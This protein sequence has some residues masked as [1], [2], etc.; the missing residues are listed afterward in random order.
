MLCEEARVLL[1]LAPRGGQRPIE[2]AMRE[3]LEEHLEACANCQQYEAWLAETDAAIRR[4][5]TDTPVPGDLKERILDRLQRDFTGHA[6]A[7]PRA[8]RLTLRMGRRWA[9]GV[10][11]TAAGLIL[12]LLGLWAWLRN[13]RPLR[14]E[15]H[16]IAQSV[17]D[18]PVTDWRL[19]P[20]EFSKSGPDALQRWLDQQVGGDFVVPREVVQLVVKRFAVVTLEAIEALVLEYR[21]ILGDSQRSAEVFVFPKQRLWIP[22]LR[23]PWRQDSTS[24]SILIWESANHYCALR[25]RGP[26]KELQPHLRL[27]ARRLPMARVQPKEPISL[28]ADDSDGCRPVTSENTSERVSM[29]ALSVVS[30]TRGSPRVLK[31]A[32]TGTPQPRTRWLPLGAGRLPG[33]AGAWRGGSDRRTVAGVD[34]YPCRRG[35]ARA[36]ANSP[37]VGAA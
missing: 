25:Y 3:A 4:L 37:A 6:A 31:V 30:C 5:I 34:S 18:L 16:T 12:A 2:G 23:E 20:P 24:L 11:A 7:S 32:A 15:V 26:F 14:I 10:A 36:I 35:L 29:R 8:Q 13:S 19:V 27:P 17:A 28:G 1:E 22:D 33:D 9:L 21:G